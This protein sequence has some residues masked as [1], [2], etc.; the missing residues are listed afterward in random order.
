MKYFL[1]ILF[2]IFF[3]CAHSQSSEPSGTSFIFLPHGLH[4]APLKANIQEPRI[5]VFKFFD[6]GQMK[7][8][9]GN[10]ID[11]FGLQN[12]DCKLTAGIDFMA[13]A[14]TTGAQG[15]R[16]Q[17]DAVD[18]FFGGNLSFSHGAE[19]DQLQARLRILHHSAH[20]VDG[21]YNLQTKSWIDNREPIP[22]TRDFGELIAAHNISASFGT[23]RY[24][25][26]ISYATLAR[27]TDVQR[28][29]YLTGAEFSYAVGSF[30]E[31]PLN[32]YIAYNLSMTGTPEY[33]ASHQVQVGCKF[34]TWREKGPTLYLAYYNGRH[35]FAEYFDERMT[36]IGA[37]F[38]VDFF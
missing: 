12:A 28:F 3:T 30:A 9:I 7:V 2:T 19:P 26:G 33:A 16:L 14:F 22:S 35:M 27:P 15:L 31:H 36:T 25:G 18:G 32:L 13:Y 38:T 6:A 5:G 20:L 4:F 10:S 8:D 1:I 17:I 11:L 34:G 37:G 21:H 29:S 23:L 24:Y